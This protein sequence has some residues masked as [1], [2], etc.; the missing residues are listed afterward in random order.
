[1]PYP[2]CKI[3]LLNMEWYETALWSSWSAVLAVSLPWV[4][5]TPSFWVLEGGIERF[6]AVGTLLSNSQNTEHSTSRAAVGK[7]I[8][9]QTDPA[10]PHREARLSRGCRYP[11]SELVWAICSQI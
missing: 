6:D 4:V 5:S 11:Y 7:L 2:F 9:A 3:F 8:P 10:Q 1:M